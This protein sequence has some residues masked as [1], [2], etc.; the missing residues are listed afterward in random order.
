MIALASLPPWN[1]GVPATG[2]AESA[3]FVPLRERAE[4][5][6]ALSHS[7]NCGTL[8]PECC[9]HANS[10]A[11]LA[12]RATRKRQWPSVQRDRARSSIGPVSTFFRAAE[13][14]HLPGQAG[15]SHYA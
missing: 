1:E 5:R 7:R 15:W 8:V 9:L 10:Q 11:S 3:E 2:S 6:P 14:V 4:R 12:D 13:A